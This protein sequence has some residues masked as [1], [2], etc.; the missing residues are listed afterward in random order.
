MKKIISLL[1]IICINLFALEI[2]QEKIK[3]ANTVLF[4]I[5]KKEIKDVKLIFDGKE[6]PFFKNTLF[7]HNF[8]LLLP[9]PY[10]QKVKEYPIS[11]SYLEDNK[12]VIKKTKIKIIDGNYKSEIIKV[13]K[14]KVTLSKKN[15][16]RVQKEYKEAM[17]IYKTISPKLYWKENFIYPL[18]TKIT[19]DFGNK[20]IY[21]NSIKS[22]HSGTDFRAAIGTPLKAINNGIIK[23]A[24]NRFYAGNSVVIDH[25][26]GVYS[27]YFHLSKINLE[28]GDKVKKGQIIGLSGDTGRV[29]G[30]HLHFSMRVNG[31]LVDPM[32]LISTLNTIRK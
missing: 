6:F 25:G 27:C 11:I 17:K 23:I 14:S 21:N 32:A 7:P 20:R 24:K 29:T 26:Q 18:N 22:Y 10:Y 12:E 31:I 2:S 8:Y 30:P 9:I 13:S 4:Q 28:V 15:K 3:N 5:E 1:L 16:K 19:S